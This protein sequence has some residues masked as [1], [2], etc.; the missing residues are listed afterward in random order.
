VSVNVNIYRIS[1][2]PHIRVLRIGLGFPPDKFYSLIILGRGPVQYIHVYSI[3]IFIFY[4]F[5]EYIIYQTIYV[6]I[7]LFLL[8]FESKKCSP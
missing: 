5:Y 6:Y 8:K 2:T 4:F 3:F 1:E 7:I